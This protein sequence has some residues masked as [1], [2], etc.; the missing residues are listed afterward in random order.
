[1]A[2]EYSLVFR[3]SEKEHVCGWGVLPVHMVSINARQVAGEYSLAY[4]LRLATDSLLLLPTQPIVHGWGVPPQAHRR[5]KG[6]NAWLGKTP[7]P[8]AA[9]R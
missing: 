8:N 5:N 4:Y 6:S 9:E 7:R 3:R 2:G 1:M